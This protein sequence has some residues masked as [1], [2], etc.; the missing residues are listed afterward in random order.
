MRFS[1]EHRTETQTFST[2]PPTPRP[3][4]HDTGSRRIRRLQISVTCASCR[5]RCSRSLPPLNASP[6][7]IP[8]RSP[9]LQELAGK[10][11][12]GPVEP[13]GDAGTPA[14]QGAGAAAGAGDRRGHRLLPQAQA[15]PDAR[16]D[17]E[18]GQALPAALR[19]R[20][21]RRWRRRSRR[22]RARPGVH[23]RAVRHRDDEGHVAVAQRRLQHLHPEHR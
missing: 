15:V 19:P 23:R 16:G 6:P 7:T 12:S 9:R 17:P 18:A 21:G 4:G 22:A 11:R 5:R 1:V 8:W 14:A 10:A 2:R 20:A 3:A 13:G